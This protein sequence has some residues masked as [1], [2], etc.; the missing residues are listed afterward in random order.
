MVL[1]YCL[2]GSAEATAA[3]FPL[4]RGM[5][6]ILKKKNIGL[7]SL[8]YMSRKRMVFCPFTKYPCKTKVANSFLTGILK[9]WHLGA[10]Q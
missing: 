4:G 9:P 1:I 3:T 6:S 2:K 7:A 5:L 8:P 10:G